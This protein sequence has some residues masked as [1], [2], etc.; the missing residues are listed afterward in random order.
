MITFGPLGR[1]GRFANALYEICATIGIAERSGQTFG[2]ETFRNYDAKERF[3]LDEDIDVYKHFVNQL[4]GIP[5]GTAFTNHDYFWG[6]LDLY[7]PYGNWSLHGQLQSHKYF[8]HCMPLVRYYMTMVDEPGHIDATAIHIRRGDYD[9][10][11]HPIQGIDYYKEALNHISGDILLFSD[12][13]NQA[14]E[15][16]GQLGVTYVPVDKNGIESFKIMK[17]CKNFVCANSS[18][19]MIAAVLADQPGK[20]ITAPANWFGPSW[21]TQEYRTW[22]AKDIYPNNCVII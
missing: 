16:M 5:E 1:L 13:L 12:D 6:Y 7:L 4:P 15:L 9:N 11:Y 17:C 21:G 18:Y 14:S 2:F 22:M 8:E 20:I 10:A 19:S 3:G